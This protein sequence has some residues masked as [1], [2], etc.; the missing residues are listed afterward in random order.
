LAAE[1]EK[2]FF[3][4]LSKLEVKKLIQAG[5]VITINGY[6]TKEGT[7][8]VSQN[9]LHVFENQQREILYI[10]FQ[11]AVFPEINQDLNPTKVSNY[12]SVVNISKTQIKQFSTEKMS[13]YILQLARNYTQTIILNDPINEQ[14]SLPIMSVSNLNLVVLDTRLTR[15]K[16]IVEVNLIQ[17]DYNFSNLNFIV[18][19]AGY[20]PSFIKEIVTYIKGKINKK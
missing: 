6:D 14:Y 20:N 3:K 9:L 7:K 10:D 19:R 17:A 18:N 16:K 2:F 4:L 8:F 11:S 15:L 1:K 13:A 12:T 5:N